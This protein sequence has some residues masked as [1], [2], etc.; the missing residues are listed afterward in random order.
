VSIL[1]CLFGRPIPLTKTA[2]TAIADLL[3]ELHLAK[4]C[5]SCKITKHHKDFS[6]SA[7]RPDGLQGYCKA[8]CKE[9]ARPEIRQ[10]RS[11]ERGAQRAQLLRD[12]ALLE[13]EPPFNA[14]ELL[15]EVLQERIPR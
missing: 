10:A 13:P 3:L 12:L 5:P 8:C 14:T 2:K 11:A 4:R 1:V 15:K 9:F 7:K 6:R